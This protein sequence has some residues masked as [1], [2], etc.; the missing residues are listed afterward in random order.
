M[1]I[2]SV[3]DRSRA[4][5]SSFQVG[6]PYSLGVGEILAYSVQCTFILPMLYNVHSCQLSQYGRD[7]PGMLGLVPV[8][9]WLGEN[10]YDV[11]DLVRWSSI[12]SFRG[13]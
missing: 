11:P 3:S 8:A 4:G 2:V 6:R 7:S 1:A 12:A 10:T 5:A 9:S 13:R